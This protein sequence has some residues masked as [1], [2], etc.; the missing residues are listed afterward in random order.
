MPSRKKPAA[1]AEKARRG[2]QQAETLTLSDLDQVRVLADPLRIRILE[3]LCDAERT[4]K[5]V[6][7]RLGEKPTKLY[8]HV[9]ALERVGLIRLARTRQNRGTMEKYYLAVARQFQADSRLF[10]TGS[11]AEGDAMQRVITTLF[12][13]TADEM[14]GLIAQGQGREGIEE[15]GVLSHLEIRTSAAHAR[16]IRARLTKLIESLEGPR[17]VRDRAVER[18]Y[19][20]TLAFYPLD[21]EGP[22]GTGG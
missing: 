17:E 12:E 1:A 5:Q 13:R 4:T 8:H 16:R 11:A 2:A 19:R 14:R 7:E 22:S 15:Q 9:E 18:R 10:S 20:L 21:P 3:Q 6:A